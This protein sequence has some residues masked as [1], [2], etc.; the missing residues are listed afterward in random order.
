MLFNKDVIIIIII[1]IT[2][3]KT[4]YKSTKGA[5]EKPSQHREQFTGHPTAK[6]MFPIMSEVFQMVFSMLKKSDWLI[7]S[8]PKNYS[9]VPMS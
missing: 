8:C 4:D 5:R 9:S 7:W 2:W 1:I 6:I 3:P